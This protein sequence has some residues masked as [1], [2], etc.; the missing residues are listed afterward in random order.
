MAPAGWC[1]PEQSAWFTGQLVKFHI[2]RLENTVGQFLAAAVDGFMKLWPLPECAETIAG[3]SLED[4]AKRAVQDLHYQKQKEQ[5]KNQF[6]NNRGKACLAAATTASSKSLTNSPKKKKVVYTLRLQRC[7]RAV[8][9]YSR[10][11]YKECLTIINKITHDTFQSESKEVKAKVLDAL[12]QLHYLDAIDATPALLKCFLGNLAVQT[13]WWFSVIAGGPDPADGGNIHTGSFHVGMDGHK[14]HFEDEY[15][16]HSIDPKDSTSRHTNFEDAVIAPYGRFL[17]TLFSPEVRAQTRDDAGT[18]GLIPMPPLPPLPPSFMPPTIDAGCCH[19]PML[20]TPGPVLTSSSLHPSTPTPTNADTSN[21]NV[22]PTS[23]P[24]LF[25]PPSRSGGEN[26]GDDGENGGDEFDPELFWQDAMFGWQYFA[27]GATE[28]DRLAYDDV[29]GHVV[30]DHEGESFPLLGATDADGDVDLVNP[31][32]P[33][34]QLPRLPSSDQEYINEDET[35]TA[36]SPSST[37]TRGSF[38]T[39]VDGEL[40]PVQMV[41][42]NLQKRHHEAVEGDEARVDDDGGEDHERRMSKRTRKPPAS[43]VAITVGWLPSAVQYLSDPNLSSEWLDLLGA[44]Q[45]LEG[46]ISGRSTGRYY[47][48]TF[49]IDYLASKPLLQRISPAAGII[50]SRVSCMVEHFAAELA[51]IGDGTPACG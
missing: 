45:V 3:N 29:L 7:L 23:H 16:H 35:D 44:W 1:T 47:I 34:F 19:S 33:A 20:S 26:G 14:R 21:S 13:G 38:S 30:L 6:N 46:L 27:T 42:D 36:D 25:F 2:A 22:L 10:R 8:Q 51:T 18:S 41:N 32:E 50:L 15:V 37:V 39:D 31:P 48:K 43:H 4:I 24:E 9:I 17:K 11:Y 49:V 40:T 12:E 28:C 5:I